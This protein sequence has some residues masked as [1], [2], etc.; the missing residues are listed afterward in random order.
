MCVFGS[1]RT[2][3]PSLL[4]PQHVYRAETVRKLHLFRV[5]SWQKK[6]H[7]ADDYKSF[8]YGTGGWVGLVVVCQRNEKSAAPV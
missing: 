5:A 4:D 6:R 3:E 1:E 7:V 2:E 8:G